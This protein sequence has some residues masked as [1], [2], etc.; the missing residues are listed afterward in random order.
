MQAGIQKADVITAVKENEVVTVK[1]YQNE[2]KKCSV[3]E[4]IK[5]KV[6]RKGAEGYVELEFDVTLTA[7]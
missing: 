5:I 7:S 4:M 6:M 2:L 1:Q 3:G